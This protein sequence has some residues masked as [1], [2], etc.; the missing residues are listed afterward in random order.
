M[1]AKYQPFDKADVI[2]HTYFVTFS[3]TR[4]V[5]ISDLKKNQTEKNGKVKEKNS[6]EIV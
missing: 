3:W 1:R 6:Q 2:E 4:K 5:E